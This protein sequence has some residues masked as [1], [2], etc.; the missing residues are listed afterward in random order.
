MD[1]IISGFKEQKDITV[2]LEDAKGRLSA[3]Q[4]TLIKQREDLQAKRDA[5]VARYSQR[6]DEYDIEGQSKH[7]EIEKWQRIEHDG[8]AVKENAGRLIK[9]VRHVVGSINRISETRPIP[10]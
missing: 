2:F 6:I 3:K 1:Q 10:L 8:D 7:K 5:L 4:A 9:Q